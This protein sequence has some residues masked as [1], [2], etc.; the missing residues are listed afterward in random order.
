MPLRTVYFI[1][2]DPAL[3]DA[4]LM[5]FELE[6]Y[7]VEG[8]DSASSFLKVVNLMTEGCL[9]TDLSM[10]EI[11]GIQL[12]NELNERQISLPVVIL[13]GYADV[14]LKIQTQKLKAFALVEK[15]FHDQDLLDIVEGALRQ[16]ADSHPII[17]PG[18]LLPIYP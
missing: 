4:L 18:D 6:G 8:F 3:R 10:P 2:N 15:P 13:T 17:S 7:D 11:D 1:D 14:S 5:L 9:V 12:L 16:Y